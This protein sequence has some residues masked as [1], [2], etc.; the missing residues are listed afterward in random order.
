MSWSRTNLLIADAARA[1]G[2]VCSDVGSEHTDSLVRLRKD[3]H[4]VIVAKTRSP[5]LTQVAQT[6]ANNKL[7]SREL[8]ARIDI[9]VVPAVLVDDTGDPRGVEVERALQRWREVVVKPNSGNRALGVVDRIATRDACARAIERARELDGDEEALVEPWIAG[10]N[11]RLAVIGGRFAAAAE[12]RRPVLVGDGRRRIHELVAELDAD[13]RRN[14]WR[15]PARVGLDRIEL[16]ADAIATLLGAHDLDPRA[17]LPAGVRVEILGEEHE[18]IDRTAE[19]DRGWHDLAERACA[20]LGVDVGGIDVRGEPSAWRAPPPT[21]Y[22][23]GGPALLEVNV[24]PALHIHALPT[25]GAPQPVFEAF[26]AYC[27]SLPGAP[28]PCA[29]VLAARS[30]LSTST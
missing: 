22:A 20:E 30:A 25:Q 3:A 7:V 16:D 13:P 5:F 2:V 23:P 9:P 14:S 1:L 11:L 27:L 19:I 15:T 28:S 29:T 8:L 4:A 12:I 21:A 18:T 10:T 17:P 6:L 26:V 24:L